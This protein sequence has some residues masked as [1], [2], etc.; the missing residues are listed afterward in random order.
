MLAWTLTFFLGTLLLNKMPSLPSLMVTGLVLL[1]A[2]ILAIV[3]CLPRFSVLRLP[4][5]FC[6]GLAWAMSFAGWQLSWELPQGVEGQ[7]VIVE[8][9]IASIPDVDWRRS[10]FILAVDHFDGAELT[11]K[12]TLSWYG[13]T[14][15]LNVGDRWQLQVRLKRPHGFANPGSF[16]HEGWLFQQGIRAL[17]YVRDSERNQFLSH[18]LFS[19]P[20]NQLR[21]TI[22]E[23]LQQQIGNNKEFAII[24]ALTIG[25]RQ[26]MSADQWAVL[27]VTGTSHL[28][29][30]SG[31]HISLIAGFAYYLINFLWRRC[32]YLCLR[33]PAQQ[34]GALTALLVAVGYAALAGFSVPTQ[35]A[36]T[37]ISVFM[38]A[39]L[40]RKNLL[41]WQGLAL[42]LLAVLLID[43]LAGMS[44][45]FY[46]SFAA[47]ALIFYGAGGRVRSQ[48]VWWQ[49]GRTQWVVTLGLMPL[50]LLLFQQT[51]LVA[52]IANLIAIPSIGLLIVPLSLI[53]TALLFVS[54]T[55][56]TWV[57]W[58][59]VKGLA[60]IWLLLAWMSALP[61]TQWLFSLPDLWIFCMAMLAVLLILAPSGWP[62]RWLGA[63][64]I[65]P[66]F[67]MAR[68]VPEQGQAWFTLLDVGQG[69]A[70]VVQ[71][72]NHNLVFDT[73]PKL[74]PKLDT[75]SAVVAPYLRKLGV[76]KID[77][78]V[79]SHGHNDHI[80]GA[81]SLL[82]QISVGEIYTTAVTQF[83]GVSVS[84]CQYGQ[85]WW[86]D[87][88]HF[89]FLFPF[90]DGAQANRN[91][92]CVL[93]VT[94]GDKQL[95]L[96][97]DIERAAEKS[98]VTTLAGELSADILVAPH[99]G[100]R[101]SS[102]AA[103]VAAVAPEYVLFPTG[104]LNR[105]RHPNVAVVQRYIDRGVQH[106]N[107]ADS[108]AIRFRLAA[109]EP[110]QAPAQY[111]VT[112]RRYWQPSL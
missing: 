46:L 97:G 85:Q 61:F 64:W 109:G 17:G 45:G 53:G 88:I 79:I 73:G 18:S 8:G 35:R 52:F 36:L 7:D 16:D 80:G 54:T 71:T 60:L 84:A 65:L 86:W 48:G 99:H 83:P 101:T 27:R 68:P 70:A 107:T 55:L 34:A 76:E 49:A 77:R 20:I 59:A 3:T 106:Y 2:L 4:M 13:R 90:P 29:A 1:G 102:T 14:P 24:Q 93:K 57:L 10:Q 105:Y 30:I 6:L 43:P 44:P 72:A 92:S 112:H 94:A 63:V 22:N 66:L 33:L 23:R 32:A 78:L 100:S 26:A 95:L 11:T 110:L 42:G 25:L 91:D 103:F 21:Q 9:V 19:Y 74:S 96:T 75:G 62:S 104:Y 51:S 39:M 108:G 40:W 89:Q 41:P 50:G 5:A 69:L 37:M 81:D 67:F 56:A 87:G 31:L 111:R 58:L 98:L 28:V 15:A 82:R 12:V 47:V 38:T